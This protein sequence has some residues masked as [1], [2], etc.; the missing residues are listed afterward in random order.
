MATIANLAVKSDGSMD[1]TLATLNVTTP[2]SIVPDARKT[3]ENEPD[4]RLKSMIGSVP[5]SGT[6][7]LEG[8]TPSPDGQ[9]R[10]LAVPLLAGLPPRNAPPEQED[11]RLAVT[12]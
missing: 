5:I 3:K 10:G 7:L 9:P 6:E 2:I 1:G 8:G 4:F 12:G 11:G